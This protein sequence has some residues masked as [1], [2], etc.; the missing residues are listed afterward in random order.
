MLYTNEKQCDNSNEETFIE[1]LIYVPAG[2]KHK[3]ISHI[4]NGH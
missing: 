2:M 4:P 3:D 1:G